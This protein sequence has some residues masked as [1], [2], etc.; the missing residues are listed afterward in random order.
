MKN[1]LVTGG[2]GFIGVNLVSFLLYKKGNEK[3]NVIVVDNFISSEKEQIKN[4][5]IKFQGRLFVFEEDISNNAFIT[6]FQTFLNNFGLTHIDDIYHLASIASP[7]YY[8]KYIIETLDVGYIGTKNVLD[9]AKQYASK[10]LF[11]S[12]SEVY[13]DP[14]ITPQSECYYGNVNTIG[15]RSNYDE[16]KRIAETLCYNYRN[17]HGI[18]I[19]IAR[20]FNTYGS[21]MMLNDGRIVTECCRA[22]LTDTYLTIY[23]DG[24]QTRS[25]CYIDDTIDM[26]YKLMQLTVNKNDEILLLNIGNDHETTVNEIVDVFDKIAISM[27]YP[28]IKRQYSS[29]DKDDPKLRR[30]CLEKNKK[31]LGERN[32][33]HISSGLIN[34]IEYFMKFT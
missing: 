21:G 34:T 7:K 8:N 25:L 26:M 18:D 27:G 11:T 2:A 19:R 30:P 24:T 12:T 15:T 31:I 22:I 23:G 4:L 29:I 5:K 3:C 13:G 16:S 9:I 1:I 17:I 14:S 6:H 20:L 32:Y 33:R 10:V 28:K